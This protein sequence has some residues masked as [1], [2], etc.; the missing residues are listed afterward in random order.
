M[1]TDHR[2]H[3]YPWLR[4]CNSCTCVQI[5][6]FKLSVQNPE[7]IMLPCDTSGVIASTKFMRCCYGMQATIV[8]IHLKINVHHFQHKLGFLAAH[9]GSYLDL[10]IRWNSP[11]YPVINANSA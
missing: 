8:T 9:N 1:V 3:A 6:W 11:L 2:A 4:D 10:G 5:S 7:L